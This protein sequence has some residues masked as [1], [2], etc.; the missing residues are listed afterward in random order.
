MASKKSSGKTHKKIHPNEEKLQYGISII[1]SHTLFSQLYN[2]IIIHDK[3]LMGKDCAAYVDSNGYIYVNKDIS[4][5]ENQWAYVIAHC[6]LHLA[7]GHFDAEHMPGYI[8]E[9]SDGSNIKIPSFNKYIWNASCNI[10]IAKFLHDIGS[11]SPICPDP[12]ASFP[13][14][15]TDELKIYDYLIE[16]NTPESDQRYG[17]AG[18]GQLDMKGLERPLVYNKN[19]NQYNRFTSLF[20]NALAHSVSDAV[21]MAGGHGEA[22]A[23][24]DTSVTRAAQWF[25]DHYPLLGGLAASFRIIED[26]RY[27]IRNEIQIAAIDVTVGE[28]YANP[29]LNLSTDEWRFVLAH[30][31]LHAGLQ[32][33]LRCQGRDPYLWNVA[34]D[35]VINGWLREMQIGQMPADGLL[36]DESLKGMSAESIYDRIQTDLKKYSKRST[37]RGYG[38]GD[39]IENGSSV[40]GNSHTGT[41]LDDFCK[42][43]LMQGLEYHT[44]SDRGFI[45]AGLIEEIRAL[46]MPPIPWDVELANWFDCHF[47]PLEK[48][49]TYSRPSRRQGSTPNI[50]RPRYIQQEIPTDSRTFGVVVDTSGSMSAKQIGMALGSIAS[51]AAAKDVPFVRVVF[52][53]ARAYDAGYLAPEDIAGRVRV[54]GRGGTVLQPGV[55]MLESAENFPK[56]GPILIITDGFIEDKMRIRHE[57]AFLLPK[58]H[59]LPFRTS[60]PVFY[61]E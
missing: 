8:T 35:F 21:S 43:A 27:C 19:L 3:I 11:F 32:H 5:T 15:L 61:F 59:R 58:G 1:K 2:Q 25:I 49:R 38:K 7:F 22:S 37:F 34:C 41:S 53:D 52:C 10:Y 48:T 30:E 4:L 23:R 56:D 50:P 60:S 13:G 45:P 42:N 26:Y 6:E 51:Y 28:I 47:Q 24:P 17:T 54:K 33:H 39:V 16:H 46:A 20:A 14:S 55:D 44:S 31:Y 18:A 36:Y 40:F 57:H 12:A 29:A 9:E